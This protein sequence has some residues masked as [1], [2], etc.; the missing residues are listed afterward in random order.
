MTVA[1]STPSISRE[2]VSV[3][4]PPRETIATIPTVA[5]T[6]GDAFTPTTPTPPKPVSATKPLWQTVLVQAGVVVTV[7]TISAVIARNWEKLLGQKEMVIE[8]VVNNGAKAVTEKALHPNLAKIEKLKDELMSEL[9]EF[10]ILLEGYSIT[11][12][13]TTSE[14]TE[15][16]E[17]EKLL[18]IL[19][20]ERV[21]DIKPEFFDVLTFLHTPT[22]ALKA[23]KQAI[24]DKLYTIENYPKEINDGTS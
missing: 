20:E 16:S 11:N 7:A 19:K 22:G 4:V 6:E 23:K 10:R 18:K 21:N 15:K 12:P 9:A 3:A 5:L 14:F 17:I 2:T 8:P 24:K 1:L 13:M